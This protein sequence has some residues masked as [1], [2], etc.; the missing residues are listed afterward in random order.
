[1][2]RSLLSGVTGLKSYQTFLDVTGNNVANV[3]TLGYK[4]SSATF[5]DLLYQTQFAGT[6]A[7]DD[8]GG[9]NPSRS[10]W[11]PVSGPLRPSTLREI[12]RTP[13]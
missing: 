1:M 11:E 2:L 9:V 6:R 12:S 10:V 4:K 5:E 13:G 7:K 3:N 8:M